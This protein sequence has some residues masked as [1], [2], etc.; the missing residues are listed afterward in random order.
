MFILTPIYI[1]VNLAFYIP[2]GFFN[3]IFDILNNDHQ[4]KLK[5]SGIAIVWTIFGL[6][7]MI[8]IFLTNDMYYFFRSLLKKVKY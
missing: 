7:I 5:K 1:V 8:V 3:H 2:F 6:P 4:R